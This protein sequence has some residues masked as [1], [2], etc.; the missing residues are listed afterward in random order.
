MFMG[1]V[2][3]LIQTHK[4]YLLLGMTL[5]PKWPFLH[6]YNFCLIAVSNDLRPKF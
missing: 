5:T 4:I 1:Q 6:P 3:L 2:G